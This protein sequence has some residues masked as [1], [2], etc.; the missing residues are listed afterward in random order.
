MAKTSAI[1]KNN[2]RKRL[3]RKYAAKRA[4]LKAII[5][6]QNLAP[7]ERFNARIKLAG[8]PRDS[9]PVRVRLRCELSGRPRG[10]YRKFKLSRIALREL[11]SIG[12]IPGMVKSS[13]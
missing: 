12:Q 6:D 1:E 9:S 11:A 13:W 10:N 8:L 2:R 3:V 5:V 7:E 4:A